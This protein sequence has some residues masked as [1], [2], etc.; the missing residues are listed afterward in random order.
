V[1]TNLVVDLDVDTRACSAPLVLKRVYSSDP[2]SK[3]SAVVKLLGDLTA[4]FAIYPPAVPRA[5]L[6]A[7]ADV[8]A[9]WTAP[10]KAWYQE[11]VSLAT[12]SGDLV[13]EPGSTTDQRIAAVDALLKLIRKDK[14]TKLWPE[15]DLTSGW[16]DILSLPSAILRD[17]AR[18]VQ[19]A[20]GNGKPPLT[21]REYSISVRL[22][23]ATAEMTFIVACCTGTTLYCPVRSRRL[24]KA[25]VRS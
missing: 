20:V 5:L 22:C 10:Q 21:A 17:R 23:C 11:L 9:T 19:R 18:T 8:S 16:A 13:R 15:E 6:R 12:E 4:G 14:L 3:L 25:S 24:R 2:A 1:R 7:G